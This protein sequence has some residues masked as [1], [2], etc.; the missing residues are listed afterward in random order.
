MF[1]SVQEISKYYDAPGLPWLVKKDRMEAVSNVS[2]ILNQG[3]CFGIIGQTGSGKTTLGR[4]ILRLIPADSGQLIYN[5]LDLFT[6]PEK[7]FRKYR[8]KFQMIFQNPGQALNPLHTVATIISEP[9]S[10]QYNSVIPNLTD[11]MEMVSLTP[12]L[13]NRFPHQLSGGQKQRVAIARAL[14]SNPVLLVADEP[15]S[16]LDA[17][18]KYQIIDLLMDIQ[19]KLNMTLL[20]ISHDFSVISHAAKTV[21]VM[22]QGHLVEMGPVAQIISDPLHPYTKHLLG[23]EDDIPSDSVHYK[24]TEKLTRRDVHNKCPF[25]KECLQVNAKCQELKPVLKKYNGDHQVACH[26]HNRVG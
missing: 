6:L 11:L 15:T 25:L 13:L 23:N 5:E 9:L 8:P 20:L 10:L 1:L 2:F 17:S 7:E 22:Y 3:E 12:D 16:S 4:C 26:L 24:S 21:G 18:L 19:K 14:A